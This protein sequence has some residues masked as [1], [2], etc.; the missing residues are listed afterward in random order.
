MVSYIIALKVHTICWYN[1]RF[2]WECQA[3]VRYEFITEGKTMNKEKYIDICHCLRGVVGRTCP[4]K[5]RTNI[6]YLSYDKDPT[7]LS[8]LVNDFLTKNVT[9]LEHPPYPPDLAAVDFYPFP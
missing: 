3:A 7:H 2:F 8:V 6:C 1:S 5:W 4:E 9:T